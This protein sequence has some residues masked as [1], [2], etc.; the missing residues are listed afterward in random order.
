[1]TPAQIRS[2]NL[3]SGLSTGLSVWWLAV[4][5]L[6][7]FGSYAGFTYAKWL[8]LLGGT[9]LTVAAAAVTLVLTVRFG[10]P[11]PNLSPIVLCLALTAW[12]ALSAYFGGYASA[13]NPEGRL[14]T[15]WGESRFEGL[16]TQ[17]CYA[18]VF[19]SQA[20]ASVKQRP[21]RIA[22]SVSLS[23]NLVLTALQYAG[24]NPLGLF[25]EGYSIAQNPEFQGTLG[26]I[27]MTVGYLA[28]VLPLLLLPWCLGGREYASLAVGLAGI[29]WL[30]CMEVQAGYLMLGALLAAAAVLA[31]RRP[32]CR[33]RVCLLFAA[34]A[35]LSLVRLSVSLPWEN[36][37]AQA[38]FRL[39]SGPAALAALSALVISLALGGRLLRHPSA[40]PV[41]TRAIILGFAGLAALAAALV[42]FLPVPE[43]AGGLWEAHEILCGRGM[44]GFGSERWGI[45]GIA[46]RLAAKHPLFGVG[47]DAF[48]QAALEEQA[49]VGLF[50]TQL[51][52]TPHNH[53][54]GVLI[55]GGVPAL[56]LWLALLAVL[57]RSACRAGEAGIPLA[58]ALACYL[59]QGMFTFSLCIITPIAA[60][61]AGMAVSVRPLEESAHVS[62]SKL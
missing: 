23:L 9:V 7:S 17:V 40:K 52:D 46:L 25:P 42:R 27:D 15:F 50:L 5:P 59:T 13:L 6:L 29:L 33:S 3:R 61:L 24:L 54:L 58:A 4:F 31:L 56:L 8:F 19:L 51:F 57:F 45:W 12:I 36:S 10:L 37:A 53:L 28:I 32:A 44:P 55:S 62:E 16:V 11:R 26:N 2:A 48:Q 60:S 34:C 49:K 41:S 35:F 38:V 47:P 39:L 22:V 14:V 18:L 21:L 43:T 20:L 1:M 30:F